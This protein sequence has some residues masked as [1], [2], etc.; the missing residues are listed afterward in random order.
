MT[1]TAAERVLVRQND[2]QQWQEDFYRDAHQRPEL[3]HHEV[4]T[5]QAIADQLRGFGFDVTDKIGS[6]GVVGVLRNGD[7]PVVL[8]RADMDALPVKEETGLPY[9]SSVT[10]TDSDG[11]T[12]P[13]MH[14][15]GHDVHVTCLLGAAK[16]LSAERDAW[17]GTYVTLFQPAE[18][19]ADGAQRML[20]GGLNALIPTPDVALA[21]HVLPLPSGTVGTCIGPV[22]SR[23]DSMRVTVWGRGSHGSMPQLSVDPAVLAAAIVQRLQGIV[24]REITPGEFAVLTIGRLAVGSK[25]NIISD[26]AIIELNIRTFSD[27]TRDA[28]VDAI[29]RIVRGECAVSGSP[30]DPEFELFGS[31]PL[32][33]NDKDVTRA[34]ADA[35]Q[36]HFGGQYFELDRQSASEDFS[37]IPNALGVP[38]TYWGIGGIDAETYAKAEAAGTVMTD[39]PA[40]HSPNFAPVIQPTLQTGTAAAVVAALAWLALD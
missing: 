40:N 19:L 12:V 6:T 24:A 16:L 28:I 5:S 26:R 13:V 29:K 39:I 30:K 8:M 34:V 2:I 7:G 27:N 38:Y 3:G 14:A 33:E 25:S 4:R 11:T 20:E 22:L 21:Q 36:R 35:F 9:A 15:C 17:S 1:K 18:E 31:F 37:D 23:G 32:T 10:A